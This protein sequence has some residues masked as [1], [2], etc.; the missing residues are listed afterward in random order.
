MSTSLNLTLEVTHT[1]SSSTHPESGSYTPRGYINL[2]PREP[3][4]D[5]AT[6]E[7]KSPRKSILHRV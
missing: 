6:D 2:R 4:D 3:T 1:S 7:P 5:S